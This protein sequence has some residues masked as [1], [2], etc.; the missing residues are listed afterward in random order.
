MDDFDKR[1]DEVECFEAAQS[2]IK[3]E[4]NPPLFF[5]MDDFTDSA[6]VKGPCG[7]SMEFYLVIKDGVIEK[8]SFYTDGCIS[9]RACGSSVAQF[10]TGKSIKDALGVSPQMVLDTLSG[11][12]G[13]YSHCSILAVSAFLSVI[14]DHLLK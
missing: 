10:V 8:A 2:I 12:P 11:L 7:D 13:S 4:Q 9:T 5:R 6:C 14:A 3:L 1:S